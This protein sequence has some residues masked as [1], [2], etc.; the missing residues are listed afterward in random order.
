M[1]A[2]RINSKDPGHPDIEE[3]AA[4]AQASWYTA[5]RRTPTSF[6]GLPSVIDCDGRVIHRER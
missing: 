6:C 4:L 3:P 5:S 1:T 2:L